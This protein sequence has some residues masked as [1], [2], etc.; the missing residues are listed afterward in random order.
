MKALGLLALVGCSAGGGVVVEIDINGQDVTTVELVLAKHVCQDPLRDEKCA[1]IQGESFPGP[2]G[3]K[4]DIFTRSV[5]AT[6]GTIDGGIA[7][8]ELPDGDGELPMAFAIGRNANDKIT[9]V[10][11]MAGTIDL[12]AGPIRYRVE[13]SPS[14]DLLQRTNRMGIAGVTEWGRG[15][16]CIGIEPVRSTLPEQR[17][18]F[19][20]DADD[21]DCD[22]RT[23]PAVECDPLWFD[24]MSF[25][26]GSATHC[27]VRS[28]TIAG[29]PCV[30]G[31]LP[32]C[33]EGSDPDA[34]AC[35]E[36]NPERCVP[37]VLC[38]ACDPSNETCLNDKLIT[39]GAD[40]R[41]DCI[42]PAQVNG[43]TAA[44]CKELDTFVVLPPG[45]MPPAMGTCTDAN[46]AQDPA[47]LIDSPL[48]HKFV[49]G[50]AKFEIVDVTPAC[51]V[52]IKFT[53]P[54]NAAERPSTVLVF[55][56]E[57]LFE[58]RE[59]WFPI[60]FAAT[61]TCPPAGSTIAC[62]YQ[63]DGNPDQILT[64]TK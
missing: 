27:A 7:S 46:F 34:G 4:D 51:T 5:T 38:A 50:S 64:C 47:A 19:I 3:Q 54:I 24:G 6:T 17:P 20:L 29:G 53:G 21:P 60:N 40:P 31:H 22:G 1:S 55:A 2:F 11:V 62:G 36:G 15:S 44:N 23:D 9:G 42:F 30:I 8:F 49:V 10:A 16:T 61:T 32:Q 59:L 35:I 57:K 41:L 45:N 39:L 37:D 52:T 48:E 63:D 12:A 14:E 25:D 26:E 13:L 28:A 18:L 58:R 33:I 56:F 43:G